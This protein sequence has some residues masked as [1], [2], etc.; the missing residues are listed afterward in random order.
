MREASCW[1]AEPWLYFWR[2]V[3]CW[4][5]LH[6]M[7]V[8]VAGL[9]RGWVMDC[10]IW[11]VACMVLAMVAIALGCKLLVVKKSLENLVEQ[12]EQVGRGGRRSVEVYSRERLVV[13]IAQHVNDIFEQNRAA[14][15]SKSDALSK[16]NEELA[17]FSHDIRTPVAVI[18][19]YMELLEMG[20]SEDNRREYL[21]RI[22]EK[23]TMMRGMIDELCDY[24]IVAVDDGARPCEVVVLYDLV[25]SV[26]ADHYEAIAAR[27]W[28]P[29]VSFDDEAYRVECPEDDLRR[30]LSNLMGNVLKYGTSGPWIVLQGD[31][32]HV[33]NEVANPG[34]LDPTRMFDRFWRGDPSRTGGGSGLGLAVA[35]ALCGRMGVS[36]EAF[37]RQ[38]TLDIAL[39][40]PAKEQDAILAVGQA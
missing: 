31:V 12:L 24:S 23:L 8:Y 25:C 40:F 1:T 22:R 18:Q 19:G 11:C 6:W 28:E 37:V 14:L 30:V 7:F 39:K 13:G 21:G 3:S 4:L 15:E 9:S 17:F 16:M 38:D 10:P 26:L 33:S 36:I 27:E 34:T 35:R 5:F 2:P 20:G 29:R 32:L